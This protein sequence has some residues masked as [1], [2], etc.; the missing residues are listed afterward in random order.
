[1]D[2]QGFYKYQEEVLYYAP[3]AVYNANFNLFIEQFESYNYPVDGW[4]FFE[5]ESLAKEFFS[6]PIGVNEK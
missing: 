3:S 4:Y 2:T 1:M 6:I 5:T